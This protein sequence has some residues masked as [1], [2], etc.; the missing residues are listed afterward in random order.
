[1]DYKSKG[2]VRV[3]IKISRRLKDYFENKSIE[4][5]LSQSSL[6]AMAL[7]EFVFQKEQVLAALND[8]RKF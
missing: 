2:I 5:G 7:D 3:N 4:T 6:M 8:N 1:M